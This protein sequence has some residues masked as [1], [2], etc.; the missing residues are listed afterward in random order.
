MQEN[1]QQDEIQQIKKSLVRFSEQGW[2][3]AFGSVSALGLFV[4]TIWLVLR[5]GI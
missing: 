1:L 2:G 3:L 5:G 4:A